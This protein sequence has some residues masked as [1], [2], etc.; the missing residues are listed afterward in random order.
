[1]QDLSDTSKV[2]ILGNGNFD[3]GDCAEDTLRGRKG[4]LACKSTVQIPATFAEGTYEVIWLWT[5][6]K[7][8]GV[9]EM[10]SS[11]MDVLIRSSSKDGIAAAVQNVAAANVPSVDEVTH[12]AI[13]MMTTLATT[14][15]SNKQVNIPDVSQGIGDYV[16]I[17]TTVG[18]TGSQAPGICTLVRPVQDAP[19]AT[20]VR[21]DKIVTMTKVVTMTIAAGT[22]ALSATT[23]ASLPDGSLANL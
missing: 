1:M 14:T 18:A 17:I 12:T 16:T 19:T 6:P 7:V 15:I 10:Y 21:R 4:P 11:C 22:D 3:D 13:V 9:V 20:S 23:L 2:K 5:F 8:T